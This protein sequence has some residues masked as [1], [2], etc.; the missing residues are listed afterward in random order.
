MKRL[1]MVV[2]WALSTG[3][4]AQNVRHDT[5]AEIQ[6]VP[7]KANGEYYMYEWDLPSPSR[8]PKGYKPVYIS[9][10]GRHGAR[11]ALRDDIYESVRDLLEQAR[12]EEQLT[13]AGEDLRRRYEAFYPS[14]A[15]RGGELTFS[16]QEQHRK[17]AEKMFRDYPSV[18]RGQTHAEVLSTSVHRVLQSMTAFLE[19]LQDLDRTFDC[20]FDAGNV[21][22]PVLDPMSSKSPRHKARKPYSESVRQTLRQMQEQAY[23]TKAFAARYFRDPAW[24]EGHGGAW[25]LAQNLRLIIVDI[26]CLDFEPQDNFDDVF[27]QEELFRLWEYRNYTGYLMNGRSPLTDNKTCLE[28]GGMVREMIEH[29]DEDLQNGN[30]NLRLRFSHDSALMPLLSFMEVDTFGASVADPYEVKD[31]WRCFEIPMACN[32]QLVFYRSR[33]SPEILVVPLLNGREAKLP[34]PAMEGP[35]YRWSDFKAWYLPRIKAAETFLENY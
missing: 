8:P 28:A 21:Y 26:P 6:A 5:W 25:A 16:G 34:F 27:T 24:L 35:F 13:P 33:R 9:H 20:R 1:L 22:L 15:Y 18:F 32:L 10:I 17:I 12:A 29:A 30:V 11:Y 4:A 23:D 2:A 31:W 19:R 14:V 3:A 7:A